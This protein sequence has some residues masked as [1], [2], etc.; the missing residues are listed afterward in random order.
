MEHLTG[1]VTRLIFR[2]PENTYTVLRLA[3]DKTVRLRVNAL[4]ATDAAARAAPGP[5]DTPRSEAFAI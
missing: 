1:R 4:A 3:P 2:N 5:H